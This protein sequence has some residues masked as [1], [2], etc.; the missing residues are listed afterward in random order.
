MKTVPYWTDN[1]P[2]PADIA[3]DEPPTEA[4]VVVIGAGI[5]GL[6]AARRIANL[7]QSV[8]V[9][10]SRE[11]GIG[12]SAINGGQLTIGL[13]APMPKVQK[14]LGL[15]KARELWQTVLDGVDMVGAI[16]EEEGVDIGYRRSGAVTLGLLPSQIDH[17]TSTA[18]FLYE[19]YGLESRILLGDEIR[20]EI[21]SDHFSVALVTEIDGLV[22]PAKYTYCLASGVTHRGGII[23]EHCEVTG[24]SR[25]GP[26][27]IVT[28]SKGTIRAANVLMATNGYTPKNLAPTVRRQVVPIGSYIVATAPL[29]RET[30][31]RI[32]PNNRANWTRKRFLNYFRLSDDNRLIFGGRPNLS[33]DL[34]LHQAADGMRVAIGTFFPQLSDVEITHVWG[35]T[36][37]ATFDLLPHVGRTDDGI[38]CAVGYG[39]HGVAMATQVENDVGGLIGGA[40]DTSPWLGLS[41]PT[42]PYYRGTPWFLTPGALAFRALDKF[43]K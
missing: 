25:S 30:A 36:L 38:W 32:L 24:L 33:P 20:S 7:G 2:K 11:I 16:A 42:R 39:G 4:D 22:D 23:V 19:N 9:V 40:T 35:G 26:G 6:S 15:K 14:R 31:K 18:Q 1:T 27:H 8:I 10:D 12:A 21:G 43:G 5:T 41:H 37:G 29:S 17:V 3:V 34:D 13:K 28:T